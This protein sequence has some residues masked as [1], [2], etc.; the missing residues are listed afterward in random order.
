MFRNC[1]F[2]AMIGAVSLLK[3]TLFLL[4][5]LNEGQRKVLPPDV[6]KWLKENKIGPFQEDE[7]DYD[8]LYEAAKEEGEV[9]VYT[10][11]SRGLE[12]LAM[13][14]YDKYP[15]IL[16]EWNTL[17]TSGT[18]SRIMKEQTAGIYT[19]DIVHPADF[20][21]QVNVLQPGNMI[22][23]WV[24]PDL[25]KV[26]PRKFRDPLLA[27]RVG[28]QLLFYNGYTWPDKPPI[29]SWWDITRPEWKGRLVIQDPRTHTSAL[30]FFITFVLNADE[31]AAD[32]TR[33][34]GKPLKLTT[35]NAGYEWLK[36]VFANGP[37][38]VKNA[39]EGRYIGKPGQAKPS[40]G[41]AW[42]FSRITDTDNPKYGNIKLLPHLTLK[43]SMGMQY[44]ILLNIAYKAPHPNAAKLLI[45]WLFGDEKG[46]GGNA[47]W[48]TP[49]YFPTRTD[50]KKGAPHPYN[51][52]LSWNLED[53]NF[54]LMD[55][56][57]VWEKQEEVLNY[58]NKQR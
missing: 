36:M 31:M 34:F 51:P 56:K 35:P 37:K 30:Q 6:E 22:F 8:A 32:Y 5:F 23:P 50:I 41:V 13:G 4:G 2:L 9:V 10:S 48:F 29:D 14:F 16:V 33:V 55:A 39:K 19:A 24:P 45:R 42:G 17:G 40:L 43:P 21:T 3:G 27:H 7:V 47:P 20:L 28:A 38:L 26:I 49:G 58:I 46:G 12:S 57:G 44:P 11:S 1:E 52:K 18:I 53:L 15:G 25:K 54:W